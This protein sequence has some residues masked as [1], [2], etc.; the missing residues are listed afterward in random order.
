MD[1]ADYTG[2]DIRRKPKNAMFLK[3][4]QPAAH[5]NLTAGRWGRIDWE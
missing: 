5:P 2:I 3:N 4:F 1:G